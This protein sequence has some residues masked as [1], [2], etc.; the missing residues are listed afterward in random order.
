[1]AN[2]KTA[3]KKRLLRL[4]H[5]KALYEMEPEDLTPLEIQELKDAGYIKKED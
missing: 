5:L 3:K 2:A 1:M 4:K